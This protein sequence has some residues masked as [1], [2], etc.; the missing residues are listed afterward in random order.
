MSVFEVLGLARA[1]GVMVVLD[2]DRLLCRADHQPPP[3][4]LALIKAHR[5]EIIAALNTSTDPQGIEPEKMSD[6]P[7]PHME[8]WLHLLVLDSGEIVQSCGHQNSAAIEL[9][10]RRRYGDALLAVTPVPGMECVLSDDEASQAVTGRLPPPGDVPPLVGS[11]DAWLARVA[12]LLECSPAYLLEWGYIDQHD[13]ESQQHQPPRAV[14]NL[15]R[16]DPRWRP[17]SRQVSAECAVVPAALATARHVATAATASLGWIT[18]RDAFH[19]HLWS[20]RDCHAPT[21]R[22]CATGADL[23]VTYER[24]PLE[25]AP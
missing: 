20:C 1:E 12:R 9:E 25:S 4:L 17:A 3:E 5:P 19:N 21:G 16:S 23:R 24:T 7:A 22:Y 14:A 18:A 13:I 6:M 10:A 15:I 2:G 8:H 11:P